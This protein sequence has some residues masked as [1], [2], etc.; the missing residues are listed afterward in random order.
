[1]DTGH[2]RIGL[3]AQLEAVRDRPLLFSYAVTALAFGASFA[4]F[5][6]LTTLLHEHAGYDTNAI[7]WLLV[8]FG[9]R[10]R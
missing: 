2:H 9:G 10:L 6:F 1:M 4:V 7:T 8:L 5:P 3:R